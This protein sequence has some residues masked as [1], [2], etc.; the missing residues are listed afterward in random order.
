MSTSL[1]EGLILNSFF[2][3][4]VAE[5][6]LSFIDNCL[7]PLGPEIV[8]IPFSD[9]TEESFGTIIFFFQF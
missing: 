7:E 2:S 5:N 9:L 4:T 6:I 3:L 8:I 1:P